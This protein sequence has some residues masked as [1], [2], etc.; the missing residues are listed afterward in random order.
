V[1]Q[2]FGAG[3]LEAEDLATL[4]I[5]SGHHVPDGAIFAGGVHALEDE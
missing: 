5:D 2:L 1:F 4:R 3:L